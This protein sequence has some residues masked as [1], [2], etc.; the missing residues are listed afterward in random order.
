MKK[1]SILSVSL[2]ALSIHATAQAQAHRLAFSQAQ[3][4]EV[5]VDQASESDWCKPELALR[6][7]FDLEQANLSAVESLM[8]KLGVLF[9]QQCPTAEK[10]T[11]QAV[12][13]T[14]AVQAS[15]TSSKQTAWLMAQNTPA[16]TTQ[17]AAAPETA[18]P[19]VTAAAPAVAQ[20]PADVPAP[21]EVASVAPIAEP[22]V[23]PA[24]EPA[25]V[26]ATP[27]VAATPEAPAAAPVAAAPAAAPATEPA[28]VAA[29][30]EVAAVPEASAAASVAVAP[31]ATPA[32][33]PAAEATTP[34]VATAPEAPAA[35]P[36][37]AAPAP[38]AR[39]ENFAVNGWQP[40]DPSQ[41]LTQHKT[42]KTLVDQQ[43]CKAFIRSDADLGQQAYTV[44]SKGASCEKGYLNGKGSLTVTRSDGAS[45]A[46]FEAFF[47][48]GLPVKTK[49]QLPL[50]DMD[51]EGHAYL[52]LEKDTANQSYYLMKVQRNWSGSWDIK[53]DTAYYLTSSKDIFRQAPSIEAV[54][55]APLGTIVKNFNRSS[56]NFLAVTDFAEGVVSHKSKHWLYE[57]NVSKHWRSNEWSFNPNNAT[58]YLFKNEAREAQ[59]AQR[60]AEREAQEAQRKA[61]HEAYLARMELEKRARQA[62]RELQSYENYRDQQRDVSELIA[63]KLTDVSYSKVGYSGYQSMLKGREGNFSQ[64]VH[65]TGE[66]KDVFLAD[67]P[68][69][70]AVNALDATLDV[71]LR[72]G[73]YVLR[74]KQKLDLEEQDSQGLPLTVVS[75]TYAFACE[76][77]G[78][79]DF[80]TP[81]NLT[82]L[83][84]NQPDWTPEY[85]Q[86]QIAD[87]QEMQQ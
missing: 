64:I 27:E 42:L 28:A 85:A 63:S 22:V 57:V 18:T 17:V 86:Q 29:T 10:V 50:V 53:S 16:E 1:I 33:E 2:L 75:P 79:D 69:P 78:C 72:K 51:D 24:T 60:K 55:L 12:N 40:K 58:N 43:G 36:V 5:F 66:K 21:A 11:W 34:E 6:F 70:L 13:K 52:L 37:A 26:V 80:F 68:Y 4:V 81:L 48:H 54:V 49:T 35:A 32:T 38:V 3:Q 62:A 39:V 25:T 19:E 84:Y 71:E 73:W 7:A 77:K 31:A 65:I 82:R 8:P 20:A 30:P 47:M 9:S 45:I 14:Q 67:Y 76:D 83:E 41:F 56:Y 74:G 87:A 61:E 46:G 44:T 23:A 59:E 15:G